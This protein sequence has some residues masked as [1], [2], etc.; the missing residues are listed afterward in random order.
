MARETKKQQTE[1]AI[2]SLVLNYN[3]IMDQMQLFN[4]KDEEALATNREWR[5]KHGISY[6]DYLR[7]DMNE[8]INKLKELG[9][10]KVA[11]TFNYF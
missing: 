8:K 5:E 6:I 2:I 4:S 9:Y 3:Y 7:Q 10:N 11:E 1:K